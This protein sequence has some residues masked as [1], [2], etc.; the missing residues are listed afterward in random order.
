M[1][2]SRQDVYGDCN[3]ICLWASDVGVPEA[4]HVVAYAH[5]DCPEHNPQP[6]EDEK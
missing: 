5:P 6:T 2:E 3:G 4:G 1:S